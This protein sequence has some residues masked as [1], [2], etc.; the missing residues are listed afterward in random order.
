MAEDV[1]ISHHPSKPKVPTIG[2]KTS[3]LKPEKSTMKPFD[4][5]KQSKSVINASQESQLSKSGTSIMDT[6]D[7]D[8]K[9]QVI[10]F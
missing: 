7:E 6:S 5:S 10:N 1:H 3:E 4:G 8:D 2:S 9:D